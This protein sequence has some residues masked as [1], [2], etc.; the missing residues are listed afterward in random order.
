MEKLT[1][2]IK[3]WADTQSRLMPALRR[4]TAKSV[5]ALE[6][7]A[8]RAVLL[9]EPR[10]HPAFE[11]TVR[12][13]RHFLPD[14]RIIVVHSDDNE[15]FV[16]EVLADVHGTFHFVN[17]KVGNMPPKS[18]NTLFMQR[19]FWSELPSNPEWVLVA[20][21]DV[22]LMQPASKRLETLIESNVKFVG[23]PWS[24]V[25]NLCQGPLDG[26][27]GHMID[28]R[29]VAGLAPDMVGNGGL[30]LRHVA[31]LLQALD[32]FSLDAELADDVLKVWGSKKIAKAPVQKGTTNEDVF[33]CKSFKDM[34][35]SIADRATGLSFA[36]EQIAPF[37]WPADKSPVALGAHKPWAYL[38][39]K[40]VKGM[41]D[42]VQIVEEKN[43][44]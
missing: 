21:T 9:V 13:L 8:N 10:M 11:F 3:V 42:R 14:W 39:E 5:T 44:V 1:R 32:R 17:C 22:M 2:S 18:Y 27:C 28:Q 43:D 38:P 15:D 29:V 30:S 34:G 33:F 4:T 26:G 25:C 7:V 37:A 36:V 6:P 24:F 35:L 40:L 23:A 16:K 20:Q 31:S 19:R 12:N 41:L